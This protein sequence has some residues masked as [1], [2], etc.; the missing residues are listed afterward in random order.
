MHYDIPSRITAVILCSRAIPSNN[1]II[2]TN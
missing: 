1:K 2:G